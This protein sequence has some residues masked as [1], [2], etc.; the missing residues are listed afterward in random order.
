MSEELLTKEFEF[1]ASVD[2]SILDILNHFDEAEKRELARELI[3]EISTE[4][5]AD[6]YI[7]EPSLEDD[8]KKK[9]FSDVRRQYSLEELEKL[10]PDREV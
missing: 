5:D 1:E 8:Y 2:I 3:D 9:H 10:L 6:L 4:Y 7:G